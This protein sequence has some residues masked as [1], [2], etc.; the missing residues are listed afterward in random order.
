MTYL[1]I[2]VRTFAQLAS[3][4]LLAAQAWDWASDKFVLNATNLGYALLGSAV[5][6]AVAAG[7]A[8][9][10]SPA[11]TAIGKAVRSAIQALL[12]SALAV[13]LIDNASGALT[14]GDLIPPALAGV[15]LAF[16][17]TLFSYQ[18]APADAS[19]ATET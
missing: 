11:S 7:W 9:V 14:Y 1:R 8:F 12:G 15:V 10:Q 2:F 16:L 18:P 3:A 6:A 19:L 13:A 17:I 5:G 4:V